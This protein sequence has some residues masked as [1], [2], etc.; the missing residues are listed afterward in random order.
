[1]TTPRKA[2]LGLI[3][4]GWWATS[5]HLPVLAAQHAELVLPAVPG[6]RLVDRDLA[7][8]EAFVLQVTGRAH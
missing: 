3:G 4:A 8:Y 1:M 7:S 2:R 5:N 6:Q